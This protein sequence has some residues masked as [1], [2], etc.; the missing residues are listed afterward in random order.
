MCMFIT[1]IWGGCG[2]VHHIKDSQCPWW[3]DVGHVVEDKEIVIS[4]HLCLSHEVDEV[5]Q[6]YEREGRLPLQPGDEEMGVVVE[7]GEGEEGAGMGAGETVIAVET[8]AEE[9]TLRATEGENLQQE[10]KTPRE[11]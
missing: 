2:C 3:R 4:A 8:P 5:W 7:E 6:E 1:Y 11:G 9:E 10:E